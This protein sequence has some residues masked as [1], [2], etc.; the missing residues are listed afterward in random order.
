MLELRHQTKLSGPLIK[1]SPIQFGVHTRN[2]AAGVDEVLR[3]TY[4]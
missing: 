4:L 1:V 2:N 3:S